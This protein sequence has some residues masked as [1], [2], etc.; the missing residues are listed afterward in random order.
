[1]APKRYSIYPS[2][3]LDKALA[4]RMPHGDIPDDDSAGF[5][6]RTATITAMVDRYAEICRRSLPRLALNEW[7]LIF[8]SLN[9]VWMQ[10]H[11]AMTAAAL[12]HEV[13][14]NCQL[15]GADRRFEIPETP[16]WSY[17]VGQLGELPF[18]AKIA[19]IDT[20]ERFWALDIQV[21]H[22]TEPTD[23]DPFAHW[24]APIR[25]LVGPM[26]D[27]QDPREDDTK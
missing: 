5:R 6:S 23:T 25:A 9:G 20:A 15:N 16:G 7:L 4:E 26:T 21:D 8:D 13:A 12:A 1:M 3:P 11:P 2:P 10:E 27:D 18:A 14:D 19:I 24:R 17:L 22:E